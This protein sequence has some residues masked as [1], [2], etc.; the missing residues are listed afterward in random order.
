VTN[1]KIIFEKIVPHHEK[2]SFHWLVNPR[3]NDFFLWHFHPEF[4]LVYIEAQA[5]KRHVGEHIGNFYGS[6]LVLIGSYIP[7][8]NFDYGIKS[9]YKKTVLHIQSGFLSTE[10]QNTPELKSIANLIERAKYGVSFGENIKSLVGEK[11]KKTAKLPYFEQFISILEIFKLLADCDDFTLLHTEIPKNLYN[12]KEEERLSKVYNYIENNY[13][14]RI[15]LNDISQLTHL[16]TAAFCRYFKKMT[17][18]SFTEF[19]NNYR[20]NQAKLML[21]NHKNVTEACFDCGFENLSYFNRTF[22]KVTGENPSS[23]RKKYRKV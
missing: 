6:D 15:S 16:S 5:G 14:Q 20:I 23:F 8:L 13:S 9:D 21:M 4:E 17:R 19:L 10:V 1:R 12:K 22:K 11:F 3:L 7:H 2:S 18:L